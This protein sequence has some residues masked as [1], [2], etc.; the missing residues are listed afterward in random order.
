METLSPEVIAALGFEVD[1]VFEC[2]A[3]VSTGAETPDRGKM[4]ALAALAFAAFVESVVSQDPQLPPIRSLPQ[5]AAAAQVEV[6]Q[7]GRAPGVFLFRS[8]TAGVSLRVPND[9]TVYRASPTEFF[10]DA[11]GGPLPLHLTRG[12]L[13][14]VWLVSASRVSVFEPRPGA[15]ASSPSTAALARW[16]PLAAAEVAVPTTAQLFAG[17]DPPEWLRTAGSARLAEGTAW[18]VASALGLTARLAPAPR[19]ASA[20][21][22]LDAPPADALA[23]D[24]VARHPAATRE[25]VA[26]VALE[27]DRLIEALDRTAASLAADPGAARH[28]ALAWLHRRDDLECVA[29]V[30]ARGGDAGAVRRAVERVDRA[31]GLRQTVWAFA[32]S[33]DDPRLGVVSW[34]EPDAWWAQ[35]LRPG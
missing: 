23:R 13:S 7:W 24:W 11:R 6:C 33:A 31:A 21:D 14:Q 30:A 1:Q 22:L 3:D 12:D 28:A 16:V 25:L 18:G 27:A 35:V 5:A 32:E 19:G 2:V 4:E 8:A 34:Q 10:V 26:H 15:A 9:A 17:V 20:I 29:F